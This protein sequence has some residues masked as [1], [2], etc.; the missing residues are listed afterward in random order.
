MTQKRV[1]PYFKVDN[2]TYTIKP[3]RFL[4]TEYEKITSNNSLSKEE[5]ILFSDYQ[6]MQLEYEEI[7]EKFRNAKTD[8]LEDV[9][10]KEKKELYKAFKE[11]VDEH[12]NNIKQFIFENNFNDLLNKIEKISYENGLEILYKALNEQYELSIEE[13]KKLWEGFVDNLGYETAREWILFMVKNLFEQEE[14]DD[15]FLKQ[16]RETEIRKMEQRKAL[17][18]KKM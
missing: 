12:Y 7:A 17:L 9:L 8:Y 13:A 16:A 1:L 5:S 4:D 14:S 15:P 18:R 2:I 11:L 6:K 10:N 3:S